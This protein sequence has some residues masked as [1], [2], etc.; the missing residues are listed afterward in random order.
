MH[1]VSGRT[2]QL[3]VET[4]AWECIYP[5]L[6]NRPCYLKLLRNV[7]M[8]LKILSTSLTKLVGLCYSMRMARRHIVLSSTL[9]VFYHLTPEINTQRQIQRDEKKTPTPRIIIRSQNE[10]QPLA[11]IRTPVSSSRA[12]SPPDPIQTSALF[13][14]H[15]P[16][17]ATNRNNVV[18]HGGASGG[19]MNHVSAPRAVAARLL[20]PAL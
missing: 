20:E 5:R 15:T 1:I 14:H 4:G 18:S 8:Y 7:R 16:S 3:G 6:R 10:V 9:Y 2:T 19:T 13:I 11:K 12:G 17:L